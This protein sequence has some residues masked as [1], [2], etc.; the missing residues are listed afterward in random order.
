MTV[1]N[2]E[3]GRREQRRAAPDKAGDPQLSP[4]RLD[5]VD[6]PDESGPL[7]RAGTTDSVVGNREADQIIVPTIWPMPNVTS[8][9]S[10]PPSTT[11]NTAR[12]LRAPPRMALTVPVNTRA[13]NTDRK[14]TG[15]RAPMG[16]SRIAMSGTA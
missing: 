11:R 15:T 8:I 4:K 7:V 13:I 5:S 10:A 12:L 2:R 14:A 16:G 1:R 9:A 3:R 6:Q